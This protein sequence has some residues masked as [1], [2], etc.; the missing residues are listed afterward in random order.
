MNYYWILSYG[1][2]DDLEHIYIPPNAVDEVKRK[3]DAG[4]PI[5]TTRGSVPARDIRSFEPSDKPY[6]DQKLLQAAAKAFNEPVVNTVEDR[7]IT[8][9]SVEAEWVKQVVTQRKWDKYYSGIPSYHKLADE[10]AYVVMAF[11]L[12]V[13]QVDERRT[14]KCSEQE[15]KSL[16]TRM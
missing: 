16:L 3:W 5:H 4:E 7:G 13:H 11:R 1:M 15:V 12:P 2:R 8:Y 9:E 6:G 14:P 10:G